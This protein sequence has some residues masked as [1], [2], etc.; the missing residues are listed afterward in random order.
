MIAIKTYQDLIAVG[1]NEQDRINFVLSV[2]SDHRSSSLCRNAQTAETYYNGENATI[3]NYCKLIRDAYGKAVPDIW[4]PNHKITCHYYKYL[5]NQLA[6]FLLGNGVS[7]GKED[8]K[9]KLG[10]GFDKAVL[11]TLINAL[12]GAVG[13]GFVNNGTVTPFSVQEFAALQDEETSAIRAGV[14]YWQI[15]ATRPLRATLYEEDG[16]TEY[17]RRNGEDMVVMNEKRPYILIVQSSEATG[18]EIVD[19]RNYPSFP[20]VPL[21][22]Y[23]KRS[24]LEGN[25]EAHDAVD[26]ML[27]GL[28]NNVDAGEIV[29]WL[30]KNSGG[31][32]Q[33]SMNQL[34][35]TLKAAHIAQIDAD[36]DIQAHST[37]VQFAASK[38][39][40]DQL[41]RQVF[42]N[43]MGLDVRNIAS[44]AATATQIRA[45]YEPL[46]TKADLLEYCVTEFIQGV[47]TVMG[48]EDVP[49]YTRSYIVNQQESIGSIIAAADNLPQSYKTRKILEILGDIDK[50][51]EV[52][53]E[54]D[55]AES[56]RFT[57]G[58]ENEETEGTEPEGAGE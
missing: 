43:H 41:R 45:A 9:E 27:S 38:E 21:Y 44:G 13:Y 8:T 58:N 56:G 31:M 7:F 54:M 52:L 20:I 28:I 14:R 11:D 24:E 18:A 29:Y 42:D 5:V 3:M 57:P 33:P 34:L 49:T 47:L 30:V 50:V 23:G 10:S 51:E 48:I 19:G 25:R 1:E 36:D 35:Q 53:A 6:L 26:L 40:L 32:D 4:S 16:Y 12:N 46:N 37:Q 55:A 2:I 15:D 22:N 17:I 39:A